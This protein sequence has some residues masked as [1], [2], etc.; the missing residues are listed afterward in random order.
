MNTKLQKLAI[1]LQNL[2]RL[3]EFNSPI[4]AYSRF[5]HVA[6]KQSEYFSLF[7]PSDLIKL[8][9]YIYSYKNTKDFKLAEDYL[10]KIAFAHLF[11]TNGEEHFETCDACGGDGQFRCDV[12]YGDRT[13]ECR[14][15]DGEG[16][17]DCDTCDGSGE[18]EE[19]LP[20]AECQGGGT[21]TCETCDGRGVE[22]C[23]NC[24]G[25]G[26]H[27]CQECDGTGEINTGTL[28][29]D[30]YSICTWSQILKDKCELE[31]GT[32]DPIMSE[33]D[34]EQF[35]DEY[36]TLHYYQ[37]NA[38]FRSRVQEG[39]VYCTNFEDEPDLYRSS[40]PFYIE[41]NKSDVNNYTV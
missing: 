12:C 19:G 16:T 31:S 18:D 26:Y 40:R 29:Y 32:F 37:D 10:N 41:L 4:Q 17:V 11:V 13:L 15:C 9:F 21:V 1:K 36:I 14:D 38:E 33:S 30:S 20:C 34:F 7:K 25:E 23:H 8:I 27:T 39:M 28:V 22:E 5:K 2:F 35:A 3:D 24:D 6:E